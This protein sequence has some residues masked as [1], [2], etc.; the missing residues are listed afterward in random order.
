VKSDLDKRE[1]IGGII[2]RP[3]LSCFDI[4]R[5][6]VALG[7]DVQACLTAFNT[8]CTYIDTR[9]LVQEHIA[10]RV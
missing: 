10:Y 9:D 2:Q 3:I 8:M 4:R 6:S 1:D 7:N 5:P